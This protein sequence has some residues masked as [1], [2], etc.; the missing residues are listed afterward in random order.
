MY[1]ERLRRGG[2]IGIR[3]TTVVL[4]GTAVF[5]LLLL[6]LLFLLLLVLLRLFL[7]LPALGRG[8]SLR[9]AREERVHVVRFVDDVRR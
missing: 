2:R 8:A 4:R 6:L 3:R 5:L 1:F 9:A 7:L